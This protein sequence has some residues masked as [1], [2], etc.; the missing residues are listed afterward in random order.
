M[1]DAMNH[2]LRRVACAAAL[3]LFITAAST[4]SEALEP[5]RL[6]PEELKWVLMPTGNYRVNFGGDE[7]T[8]GMYAYRVR[9]P[10]GFRNQPHFHPDD[11]V[12][13]VISGTLHVGYGEQ[14]DESKMKALHAGSIWTEPAK[15][16]HFVWA[17]DGEVVIQ[18]IGN[19]PS[20]TVPVQSKQ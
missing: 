8:P 19:G 2:R 9:F 20:A 7:K 3:A 4:P 18:V 15:E 10:S 12:V 11:R 13:T 16:P 1:E 14:F 5:A 6:T 17:K